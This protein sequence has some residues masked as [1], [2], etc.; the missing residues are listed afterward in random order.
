[1]REVIEN[2][3]AKEG[4]K[5]AKEA[6]KRLLDRKR[7]MEAEEEEKLEKMVHETA[8]SSALQAINLN[9]LLRKSWTEEKGAYLVMSNL[10]DSRDIRRLQELTYNRYI[11]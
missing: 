5:G 7:R 11:L 9:S 8:K 1:M 10:K 3:R 4:E 2:T 6:R